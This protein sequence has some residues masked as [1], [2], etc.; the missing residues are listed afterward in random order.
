MSHCRETQPV[1][2]LGRTLSPLT[3][4]NDNDVTLCHA[5]ICFAPFRSHL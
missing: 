1:L 3:M 5:A 2:A 4:R